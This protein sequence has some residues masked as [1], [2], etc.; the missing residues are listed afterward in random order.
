MLF[1]RSA[2]TKL[3]MLLLF[4]VYKGTNDLLLIGNMVS[5]EQWWQTC[6]QMSTSGSSAHKW[7]CKRAGHNDRGKEHREMQSQKI[8]LSLLKHMSIE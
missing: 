7:P 2:H 6:V 1:D 8:L 3:E 4:F 5:S